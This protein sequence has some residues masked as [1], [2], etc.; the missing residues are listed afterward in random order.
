MTDP[1]TE[2]STET[3]IRDL[4]SGDASQGDRLEAIAAV[5][6]LLAA[7]NISKVIVVDDEFELKIEDLRAAGMSVI[8]RTICV[9][10]I[11]EVDFS[12]PLEIW[13]GKLTRSW[14][15]LGSV[16]KRR[17][18]ED[19]CAK[20]SMPIPI[21][22][23][24]HLFNEL[25]PTIDFRGMTPD[26]W[27]FEK[28][29]VINAG[30][31]CPT[32]VLFDRDLGTG[33]SNDGYRLAVDLYNA[34]SGEHIWAGLL[35]NT[36]EVAE[37]GSAWRDFT[38]NDTNYANR[39]ILLS[40]KHLI[41]DANSFPEALRIIL[42]SQPASSL[43]NQVE[44][45]I[46]S[47]V[48]DVALEIKR[49]N[50]PEFERIVFGLAKNEG[51]WEVDVLLRL[52]DA[53]L[54]SSVRDALHD[55]LAVRESI[56]LLRSLSQQR[57]TKN[58]VSLEAQ[59][60]Y[61]DEIYER[62]E[63]LNRFHLPAELGDIYQ[64]IDHEKQFVLVGQPC[65]LMVRMDGKRKPELSFVTLLPIRF[66]DPNK[67]EPESTTRRTVFELPAF[68][69]GN[70]AWVEIDRPCLVPV[71]SVDY[72]ALNDDGRGIAPAPDR[73]PD[74]IVP[75]WEARW[76]TLLETA[77]TLRKTMNEIRTKDERV[78]HLK[79]QFGVRPD[80]KARPSVKGNN[81][82]LGL[83]RTGRILS[84]YARALLTSYSAHVARDA[85]EPAIA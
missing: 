42:I 50:T 81:F 47:C 23:D 70:P 73:R 80:C 68:K 76:E 51:V 82:D 14:N 29:S 37:E 41:D 18:L 35:T 67:T 84:P 26:E 64:K 83:K 58:P 12:D 6:E 45:A 9:A 34:D 2:E 21:P 10:G 49:L 36:I 55:D 85:F 77:E 61:R 38:D 31:N 28:E 62:P 66:D 48:E 27:E 53:R 30:A 33:K 5:R 13:Q 25:K 8:G 7:V 72:C 74:W 54:R 60:I 19:L 24:L 59:Y 43:S 52:F 22:G 56:R 46:T 39:F 11:G 69:E 78:A 44:A 63:H 15:T 40:K 57:G 79:A 16:E 65:D 71:E 1:T 75:S 32:M 20:S 3:S 17:A 4:S